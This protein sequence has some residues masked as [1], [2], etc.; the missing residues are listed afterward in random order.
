MA[1]AFSF[2]QRRILALVAAGRCQHC[3][4]KLTKSF[5]ADHITAFSKGGATVIE[6]GQALCPNCNL[7]KGVNK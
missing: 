7:K 5:H 6:N 1:R 2:R 4:E 3:K